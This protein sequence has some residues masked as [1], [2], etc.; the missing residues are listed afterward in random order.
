MNESFRKFANFVSAAAGSPWAF[1]AALSS[2]LAWAAAGPSMKFSDTWM[3]IVGTFTTIATYLMVFVIQSSQNR[4]T[5]AVLL[6]LDEL[7]RCSE[8]SNKFIQIEAKEESIIRE[9]T[10]EIKQQVEQNQEP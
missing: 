9:I 2:V 4:D 7:I 3:L 10:E 1:T 6:K 8:A 5:K